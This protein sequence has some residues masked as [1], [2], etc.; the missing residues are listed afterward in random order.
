MGAHS[1]LSVSLS[2]H[3]NSF[4]PTH[5]PTH[6]HKNFQSHTSQAPT[7]G[8]WV[9]MKKKNIRL[10]SLCESLTDVP[11]CV[12]VCSH[13][14]EEANVCIAGKKLREGAGQRV[15]ACVRTQRRWL[16]L[17][18]LWFL[19]G[20]GG[21]SLGHGVGMWSCFH[22]HQKTLGESSRSCPYSYAVHDL[23]DWAG[24]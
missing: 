9:W 3:P 4:T 23:S 13:K 16:D 6:T 12:C 22:E 5:T 15:C 20:V 19:E 17:V 10:S 11:V 8:E 7:L 18:F 1:S 14:A 24:S 2:S 21:S